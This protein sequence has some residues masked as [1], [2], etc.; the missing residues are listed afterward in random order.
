MVRL[1]PPGLGQALEDVAQRRRCRGVVG[2]IDFE[3]PGIA[4]QF[5]EAFGGVN[6]IEIGIGNIDRAELLE[7]QFADIEI[8]KSPWLDGVGDYGRGIGA[9]GLRPP[10]IDPPLF[11]DRAFESDPISLDTELA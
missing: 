2:E 3:T 7:Q 11:T 5:D 9:L 6:Q 10:G 4:C 1:K 8:A